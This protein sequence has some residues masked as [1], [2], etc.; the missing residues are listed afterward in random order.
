MNTD[1]ITLRELR[2]T[3]QPR[4]GLDGQPITLQRKLTCRADCAALLI[5]LLESEP[6][7]VFM[8]LCL[9]TKNHL[10]GCHEVSRGTLDATLVHPREVF[11]IAMLANAFRIILGHNHPSGDPTP[12]PDDMEM[13]QRLVSAGDLLG[14]AVLDHVIVGDGRTFSFREAGLIRTR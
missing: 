9:T 5:P 6:S 14:I 10:I 12:S 7:E 11:K 13:T 2:L 1:S 8:V 4:V 3:Y